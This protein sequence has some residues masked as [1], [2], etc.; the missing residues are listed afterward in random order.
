MKKLLKSCA[1]ILAIMV[2]L[3]GVG[4]GMMFFTKACPPPGPWP[5]P[6]WCSE[7]HRIYQPPIHPPPI[8]LTPTQVPLPNGLSTPMVENA[9]V[10]STDI[11]Q[12]EYPEFYRHPILSTVD[13]LNPYCALEKNEVAYPVEYLGEYEFPEIHGAPLPSDLSRMVGLK[14]VWIAEPN[15]NRCDVATPYEKMRKALVS[16]LPRIRATGADGVSFTNY[17]SFVDFYQPELQSPAQAAVSPDDLRYVAHQVESAGLEMTLYLNLAPGDVQVSWEIPGNEWL[18]NLIN[19]WNPFVIEQAKIA[20][21]TGIDVIMLNHFDYQPG[22]SGYE[23]IFETEMLD[24]LE[25]TRAV[26]SGQIYLMIDPIWGTDL[27]KLQKLLNQVDGYIYTP[28]ANALGDRKDKSV[29]VSNLKTAYSENL[30]ALAHDF[31]RF[32]KPFILRILI[33]SERD[34][35][36]KGWNEDMFCIAK[37]GT[38]CYQASLK[39]DFSVQAIAYEAML[40]SVAEI[41]RAGQLKIGGVDAYGYW[42]TDV[43]LPRNS[44]PQISQSVRNKPAESIL[45]QWF[46]RPANE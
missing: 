41:Q 20:E 36:E 15:N 38:P 28:P 21:E 46:M 9:L 1:V 45:Y 31:G 27:Q 30:K 22:I 5:L 6:P 25:K 13:V 2:V 44:Q 35:L 29:T 8:H 16:T 34:F 42:Y 7:N 3:L 33:Q 37:A 43:I 11:T 14:D 40:E 4:I 19:Q 26:Y 12:I 39:A 32:N 24:L 10:I 17:L 23:E 18:A